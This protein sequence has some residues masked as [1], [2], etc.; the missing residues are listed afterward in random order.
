MGNDKAVKKN[1]KL[2]LSEV[3]TK[4]PSSVSREEAEA[5]LQQLGPELEALEELLFAAGQSALL[6]VLQGVDTSGKDGAIRKLLSH[7]N[8]QSCRVEPFKVPTPEEAAHDFLW[9]VHRATP[10]K[11]EVTI[12]NR[13]HYEDVIVV[14]VHKLVPEA[15]WK[16]RYDH[17]LGFESLLAESGVII[18]KFYLHISKEEQKQ[19]LLERE[20]D[21]EKAWKLSV[22][23]W[24]E[25]ELWDHYREAFEDALTKCSTEEAPWYV[26]P[27]DNKWYRDLFIVER[28]VEALRP[29]RR[30]WLE[31]LEEIGKTAK[32]EIEA[33]RSGTNTTN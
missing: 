21:P 22:G 32:A 7:V 13:S 9:R 17:I 14:R 31:H 33:Y 19:R 11:G 4:A 23:D 15:V 26:V 10:K 18:L 20:K 1:S 24:K 5:R 16:R 25:R 3:S 29:Y 2:N 8:V 30:K 12:F 27:A 28:I 6:V